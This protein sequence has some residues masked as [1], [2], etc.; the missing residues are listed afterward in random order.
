[1]T[2]PALFVFCLVAAS[3]GL[4]GQSQPP[5]PDAA[6]T[7]QDPVPTGK[8]TDGKATDG[9]ATDGKA[10]A[11]S[12][13]AVAASDALVPLPSV[14]DFTR[15]GGLGLAL[16]VGIE[17]EG[18][19]DGADE[20]EFGVEPVGVVQWRTGD[21]VFFWEGIEA[22]WRARAFDR[23]LLQLSARYEGG[24]DAGDSD[25]GRLDGLA[26]KD[27]HIVGSVEFRQG[28]DAEWRN[29]VGGKALVGERDFGLLGVLAAGH[30]FGDARDG[31]G[32]ELFG[33]VS[34]GDAAFLNKDFGITAAEAQTSGLD[35]VRLSGGFRATGVTLVH[36]FYVWSK[37]QVI[38]QANV[39]FYGDEVRRSAIARDDYEAE[40]S[41][42]L[43]W[44]F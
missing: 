37:L 17:Y 18:A 36:R 28:L 15:G 2:R 4:R 7:R 35:A 16:G 44:V 43:V 31:T 32:T 8:A 40:V 11:P 34:F 29:W 20:Y 21:S 13:Q 19:Y 5:A 33:Y 27:D 1:M 25:D 41:V 30:R 6:P 26:T 38:A 3:A 9:K 22:G 39:E 23:S 24:R 42:A 10:A 12:P 14:L